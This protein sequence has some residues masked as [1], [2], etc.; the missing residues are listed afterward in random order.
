MQ[1]QLLRNVWKKLVAVKMR[2]TDA[3]R[4]ECWFKLMMDHSY[5][6]HVLICTKQLLT[7]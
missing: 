4:T 3:K 6:G 2:I 1:K 5:N 7:S